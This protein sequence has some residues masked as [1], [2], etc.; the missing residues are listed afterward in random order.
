MPDR[1]TL[2]EYLAV[3]NP[4]QLDAVRH[5]GAPLLILAG[6]GSGKTRVITTKIAYLIRER[7]YDPESILAVTFT[8]KAAR[9]M[10]ER[11]SRIEP[12]AERAVLRTFHS[13]GAWFLRRNGNLVGLA[14][15]FVIYD[16]DDSTTLLGSIMEDAPRAQAARV[17]HLIARAKDYFLSPDDPALSSIDH[18]E[19]FR[20]W[21]REYEKRLRTI[22]NVDF[23]DLI[24]RPVELLRDF[25]E[26]RARFR[27]R[28]ISRR[29]RSRTR[30]RGP[31]RCARATARGLLPDRPIRTCPTARRR[32]DSTA[33]AGRD[34]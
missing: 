8:N 4:E 20:I 34:R 22:G 23:G 6:A 3:L 13:F 25:P 2:P 5:E 24:K 19:E 9:E 29:C 11:A 12:R 32:I 30:L 21:Y 7:G 27:Q 28:A 31:W 15:K 33:G 14:S 18:R 17:A 26:V 16:D 1:G 10:A